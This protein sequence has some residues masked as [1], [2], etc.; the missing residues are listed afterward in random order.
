MTKVYAIVSQETPHQQYRIWGIA[1]SRAEAE[2]ACK[3]VKAN[4]HVPGM[5]QVTPYEL[6]ALCPEVGLVWRVM[7]TKNGGG[8]HA[9]RVKR[10]VGQWP[11]V[12]LYCG[13]FLAFV[14]AEFKDDA[15][16]EA[17]QRRLAYKEIKAG[18]FQGIQD[19]PSDFLTDPRTGETL[20][21][22]SIM[23]LR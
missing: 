19:I 10:E 5:L 1:T 11:I 6:D 9:T 8:S 13:S 17:N 18:T 21:N 12:Q 2:I 16:S 23:N 7:M 22:Y 20:Y 15:V 3:T 4:N 14:D